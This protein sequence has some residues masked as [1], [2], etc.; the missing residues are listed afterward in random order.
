MLFLSRP[1]ISVYCENHEEYVSIVSGHSAEFLVLKP[2]EANTNQKHVKFQSFFMVT[3]PSFLIGISCNFQFFFVF[4][5]P[6]T[7]KTDMV[8]V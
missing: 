8:D 4:L 7:A 6:C 2:G 1:T 5:L 3:C